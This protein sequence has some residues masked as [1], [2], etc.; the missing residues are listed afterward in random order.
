VTSLFDVMRD[1]DPAM[2]PAPDQWV[3]FGGKS[4]RMLAALDRTVVIELD[5]QR[6]LVR[7]DQV[8]VEDPSQ[9]RWENKPGDSTQQ[10]VYAAKRRAQQ[11]KQARDA[12]LR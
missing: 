5:G 4:V 6:V 3:Q 12:E 9:L 1:A 8:E 11:R 10:T 2:Q 7:F